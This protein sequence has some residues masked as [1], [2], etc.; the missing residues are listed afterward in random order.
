MHHDRPDGLA[1]TPQAQQAFTADAPVPVLSP[2]AA[3]F[4]AVTS[5]TTGAVPAVART[6]IA[7]TA[8]A[9][10][11]PA[12]QSVAY[13]PNDLEVTTIVLVP[14]CIFAFTFLLLCC[15]CLY[16]GGTQ[17]RLRRSRRVQPVV[18]VLHRPGGDAARPPCRSRSML[19]GVRHTPQTVMVVLDAFADG[20]LLSLDGALDAATQHLPPRVTKSLQAIRVVHAGELFATHQAQP[21]SPQSCCSGVTSKQIPGTPV[22]T[23]PA[24]GPRLIRV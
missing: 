21:A 22:C 12:A 8:S 17:S 20:T 18:T 9:P 15:G 5:A 3:P 4:D 6:V 23:A 24:V 16:A 14:S 1:I 13:S 10:P 7:N 2:A 19:D 11:A